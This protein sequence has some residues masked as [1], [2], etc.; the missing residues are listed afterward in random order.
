MRSTR[1]ARGDRPHVAGEKLSV[2]GRSSASPCWMVQEC[3]EHLGMQEGV[4]RLM[5]RI[6][7][8][9]HRN[10]LKT[11]TRGPQDTAKLPQSRP[12]LTALP[13]A[14]RREPALETQP[15][16]PPGPTFKRRAFGNSPCWSSR[17]PVCPNWR[18][19]CLPVLSR[20]GPVPQPVLFAFLK[21]FVERMSPGA[22]LSR[23][24][25]IRRTR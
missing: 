14:L 6:M 10:T 17:P 1:W 25:V 2:Q 19:L 3:P 20:E 24:F 18:N 9:R 11:T 13:E 16:S 23:T 4:S 15:P 5:R 7:R 21:F 12:M 22:R 8:I